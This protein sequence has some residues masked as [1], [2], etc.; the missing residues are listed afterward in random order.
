MVTGT[1]LRRA[2]AKDNFLS[3]IDRLIGLNFKVASRAEAMP[4]KVELASPHCGALIRHFSAKLPSST[5]PTWLTF[6]VIRHSKNPA[7]YALASAPFPPIDVVFTS[8]YAY[9]SSELYQPSCSDLPCSESK[10]N[11][12]ANLVR[13]PLLPPRLGGGEPCLSDVE[14]DA[15]RFIH[16]HRD[17]LGTGKLV[18]TS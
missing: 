7:T 9:S 15:M 8:A 4:E 16:S 2:A 13:I 14:P 6:G 5:L 18:R 17:V 3:R 10:T 12:S 1:K 11:H